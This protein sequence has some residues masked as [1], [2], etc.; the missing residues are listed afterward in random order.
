MSQLQSLRAA[1]SLHHVAVLL[2]FKPKYLAY[3]LY[4]MPVATKYHAF[5]IAKRGGGFREINAPCPELMLLQRKLSDLLQNCVEEINTTR[6]YPDQLAHGFKRHHSIVTN[7]F[8]HRKRKYVFNID[9]E[10]FFGTINFG[11]VRG[12]FIKNANFMLHPDV[13]TVLAQIACHGKGLP[14]GSP[15]SPVISNLVS[16]VLDVRLCQ[17]ASTNGCT[18][19][20]YAD[21]ISFSTNKPEF[22]PSIACQI[23]GQTHGWQVGPDL[24]KVV[25]RTGFTINAQKTRLQYRASRQDVTGL[26]VNKKVNIRADYRRTVRAM[27]QRLFSTGK[28]QFTQTVADVNGVLN[29]KESDGTIAQLHGMIGHI[30]YVD[31]ENAKVEAKLDSG[32]SKAKKAAKDALQ[33]KQRL[34][35]RFLLFKDFYMAPKAVI[36][37]EG[38]TDNVYLLHAID[39]LAIGYPKL[40]TAIPN[41]K[42]KLEVRILRTFESSAGRILHLAQGWSGLKGLISAYATELQKFKAPGLSDPAILLVDNDNAAD[43]IFSEIKRVA[44]KTPSKTDPYIHVLGNLYVVLTPLQGGAAKSEIED[45]FDDSIKNLNLGGKVFSTD[46]NANANLYFGKHILSQYVRHNASKIDFSGFA[47]ILDRLTAAIE[48]YETKSAK[49]FAAANV[50]TVP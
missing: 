10:D 8:K 29:Q 16:S 21:D 18:Y 6:K 12:Y 7:A 22:P 33:S 27:A 47:P 3:I 25:T 15:C 24:Q 13:A 42:T 46:S 1:S 38:K 48:D 40:A 45:C 19:S 20:R 44:G 35:R 11:R 5:K 39:R 26:V 50:L 37:C 14:Q 34:Y 30:D 23:V 36:V 41:K 49:P 28:F 31:G 2:Q 17:L 4:K 43:E 32:S 9:L